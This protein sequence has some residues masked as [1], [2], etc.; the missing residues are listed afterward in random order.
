MIKLRKMTVEEVN[1]KPFLINQIDDLYHYVEDSFFEYV[2][3]G[4]VRWLYTTDSTCTILA[5]DGIYIAYA[6]FVLDEDY[7]ISYMEFDDFDVYKHKDGSLVLLN[8][9]SKV[10]ESLDLFNRGEIEEGEQN[11][12]ILYR[13]INNATNEEMIIGYLCNYREPARYFPFNFSKP[14]FIAFAKGNKYKKFLLYETDLDYF[15]YDIITIKEFGILEVLK[16]GAFSLQKDE[17]IQRYFSVKYEDKKGNCCLLM[18]L[19]HPYKIEEIDKIIEEKGFT[20]KVS[21]NVL[22]YYNEVFPEK[23]EFFSLANAIAEY[24]E[25]LSEIIKKEL[26]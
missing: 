15:S 26:K 19:S 9:D 1:N 11:G 21:Q 10:S 5:I 24:G 18:P 22:D 14:F 12:I 8:E 3:K 2:Y 4:E 25:S 13:Q 23:E 20:R 6:T 7:S 16:N 17:S